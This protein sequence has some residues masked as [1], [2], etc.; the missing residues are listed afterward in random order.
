[1]KSFPFEE[2]RSKRVGKRNDTSFGRAH[3]VAILATGTGIALMT[4]SALTPRLAHARIFATGLFLLGAR[5]QEQF[6]G[7]RRA[8]R[9]AASSRGATDP[10]PHPAVENC[11]AIA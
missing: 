5:G 1:M 3:L 2:K 7:Q 11:G 4:M 6:R 10:R 9:K 8:T